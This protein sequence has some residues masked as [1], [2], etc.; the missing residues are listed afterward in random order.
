MKKTRTSHKKEF[1]FSDNLAQ[2]VLEKRKGIDQNW[3]GIENF[4]T[5][6]QVFWTANANVLFLEMED[7]SLGHVLT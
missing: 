1:V 6:F 7:W 2:N 3:T 4:D 5:W